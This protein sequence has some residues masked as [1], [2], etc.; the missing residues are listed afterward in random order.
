MLLQ[1][2]TG[3]QVLPQG[4]SVQLAKLT[5]LTQ[6]LELAEGKWVTI[7]TDSKYAFLTQHAHAAL[8]K[9]R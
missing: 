8:W 3:A 6:A 4:L 2:T 7:Y 5:A 9:E 1:E